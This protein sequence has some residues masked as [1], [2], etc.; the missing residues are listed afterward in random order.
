MYTLEEAAKD[1]VE[2]HPEVPYEEAYERV[3]AFH[4]RRVRLKRELKEHPECYDELLKAYHAEV[5]N[6]QRT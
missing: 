5:A 2:L 1:Y 6:E 4:T 3:R